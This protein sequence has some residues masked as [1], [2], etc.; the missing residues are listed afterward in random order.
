[1]EFEHLVEPAELGAR[2]RK[3]SDHDLILI[4]NQGAANE[5][6]TVAARNADRPRSQQEAFHFAASRSASG[7]LK[8]LQREHCSRIT[9][10]GRPPR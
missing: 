2:L 8:L 9:R 7:L 4:D 3:R 6:M 5:R 10:V 1:M